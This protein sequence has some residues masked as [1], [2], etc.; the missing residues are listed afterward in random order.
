MLLSIVTINYN[1]A[2]G[3]SFTVDSVKNQTYENIEFI[4]IDGNSKDDS[5]EIIKKNQYAISYWISEPDKGIYD[6]MNKG[7][8]KATGDF[9]LFLNSGDIF[10]NENVLKNTAS[11]IDS[12]ECTYFCRA[13]SKYNNTSWLYP[14]QN[15]NSEDDIK[16]WLDNNEPNHQAMFFPKEF[17]QSNLYDLSFKI[18][19]DADYKHRCMN[20]FKPQFI[21]IVS[22]I[23][24]MGGVSSN[25]K[26][27]KVVLT[28]IKE[29]IKVDFKY[30]K[31]YSSL[32][33]TP[34]KFLMKFILNK[35]GY[36][37]YIKILK[38]LKGYK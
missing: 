9:I 12:K 17:Y 18:M 34:I 3:L 37:N 11:Y 19:G 21:D 36:E 5:V 26:K 16:T 31:K 24:E 14:S 22:T 23:F 30:K 32:L 29:R 25:P 6:A 4:I 15:I 1:N 35:I 8:K 13:K 38:K 7:I 28:Q 2:I 27:F 10:Y 33:I 20:N